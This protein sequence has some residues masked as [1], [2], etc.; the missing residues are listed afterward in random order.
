MKL[1][2]FL[3]SKGIIVFIVLIIIIAFSSFLLINTVFNNLGITILKTHIADDYWKDLFGVYIRKSKGGGLCVICPPSYYFEKIEGAD[4]FT[5]KLLDSNYSQDKNSIFCSNYSTSKK[6]NIPPDQ[7]KSIKNGFYEDGI[8]IWKPFCSKIK[9]EMTSDSPTENFDLSSFE[10][11]K[12][13]IVKDKTGVYY[14]VIAPVFFPAEE[15]I[16]QKADLVDAGSFQLYKIENNICYFK[17]KN[18]SYKISLIE[19][20]SELVIIETN[21]AA[22]IVYKELGCGFKQVDDKIYWRSNLIEDADVKT[23]KPY[24][25]KKE[26]HCGS[27][28]YAKDD[29]NVFYQ[30]KLLAQADLSTFTVLDTVWDYGA[31]FDKNFRYY[32][33]I[34]NLSPGQAAYVRMFDFLQY[35]KKIFP[36]VIIT[37]DKIEIDLAACPTNPEIGPGGTGLKESWTIGSKSITVEG[38]KDNFCLLEFTTEYMIFYDCRIPSE[39]GKLILGYDEDFKSLNP[40]LDPYKYCKSLVIRH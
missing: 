12:C 20:D 2:S 15:K 11:L 4:P 33:E 39:E 35:Q 30:D 19:G 13:G 1:L 16:L 34:T 24:I 5:F 27:G 6:L 40:S 3:K 29:K 21:D 18:F 32:R 26:N 28:Y 25:N 10:V 8:N 36:D 22:N 7:F 31:A 17:D 9:K 14:Y 38:K 23:F 37:S